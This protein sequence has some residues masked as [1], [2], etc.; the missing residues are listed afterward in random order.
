MKKKLSSSQSEVQSAILDKE[1]CGGEGQHTN[2]TS[3]LSCG[4]EAHSNKSLSY[5]KITYNS[6]T[7]LN[8]TPCRK[9]HGKTTSS[10]S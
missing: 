1:D 3:S 6:S 5:R 4:Y 8:Q 7:I 2:N 10:V 9:D